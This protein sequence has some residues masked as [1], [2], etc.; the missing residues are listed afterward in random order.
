MTPSEEI[1]GLHSCDQEK[2]GL[3]GPWGKVLDVWGYQIIILDCTYPQTI[4]CD[5]CLSLY[6]FDMPL[7][8]LESCPNGVS[9]SVIKLG[10]RF[11]I[12]NK[13]PGGKVILVWGPH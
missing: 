1:S 13:L 4:S 11:C 5:I 2:Q 9:D 8:Y 3:L 10:L 6:N 12:S 7:N